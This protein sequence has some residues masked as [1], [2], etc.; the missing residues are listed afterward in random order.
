MALRE[1][2]LAAIQKMGVPGRLS[3]AMMRPGKVLSDWS[4]PGVGGC[5]PTPRQGFLV[6]IIRDNVYVY[7]GMIDKVSRAA[8]MANGIDRTKHVA[9]DCVSVIGVMAVMCVRLA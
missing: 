5:P 2:K 8:G 3:R 4:I 1:S 7:G 6:E 9:C